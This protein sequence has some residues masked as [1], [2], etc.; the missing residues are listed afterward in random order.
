MKNLLFFSQLLDPTCSE[1]AS[2][3]LLTTWVAQLPQEAHDEPSCFSSDI[4]VSVERR[5][6]SLV[7]LFSLL[8][9]FSVTKKD[10]ATVS[11]DNA[12]S[13]ARQVYFG[14]VFQNLF[15]TF[16]Q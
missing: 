5:I 7:S 14:Q 13:A 12:D 16:S 15:F 1:T 8:S 2:V 9:L 3:V 6:F 10:G 4:F 11:R